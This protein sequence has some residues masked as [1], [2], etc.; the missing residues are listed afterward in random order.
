MSIR[1]SVSVGPAVG[2]ST[3]LPT[4]LAYSSGGQGDV[5]AGQV[6]GSGPFQRVS[7]PVGVQADQVERDRGEHV[8]QPGLGQP[9]VAGAA[10]PGDRD[11]LVDGALDTGPSGV[12]GLPVGAGLL[13][14]GGLLGLVDV[15]GS[16]GELTA[17]P[18]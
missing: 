9:A 15:A 11:G 5:Q 1:R 13:G 14:A 16:H 8:L 10:H 17:V 7:V 3:S 2:T 6:A 4:L 18:W 12:A